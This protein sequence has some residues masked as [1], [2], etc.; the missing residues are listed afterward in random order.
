MIILILCL[1]IFSY[2]DIV[3]LQSDLFD[4]NQQFLQYAADLKIWGLAH[5]FIVRKIS[6]LHRTKVVSGAPGWLSR[7]SVWLV[8]SAQVM[9]S[10]LWD[11]PLSQALHWEWNLL[12][13]LSVSLCP[14]P[15]VLSLSHSPLS[16]QKWN[17]I[18]K[19]LRN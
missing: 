5:L 14:F 17:Q 7:L 4:T 15:L 18:V 10:G 11:Q 12:K 16:K 3:I 9:V 13:I 8:I 19:I 1:I 2:E 6:Q